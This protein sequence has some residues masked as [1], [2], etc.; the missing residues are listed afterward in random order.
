[1]IQIEMQ[2]L[3]DIADECV[4]MP[5]GMGHKEF[6][7][8][9]DIWTP[10]YRFLYEFAREYKP[11]LI[12]ECG[13][14]M[15]TASEHM[16]LAN[17]DGL[18]I[19]IDMGFHPASCNVV[20][21]RANVRYVHGN[22]LDVYEHVMMLSDDLPLELLFLDSEHDGI[23]A[24]REFEIYESLMGEQCLVACDDIHYNTE[25][26]VWWDSIRNPKMELNH[27]H[28]SLTAGYV[29]TGFGVFIVER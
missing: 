17:P 25:M 3:D 11:K 20:K 16:A 7:G 28:P 26:E 24:Q 14:Y 27:L 18:V 5:W 19:G 22:T 9:G 8:N 1:M 12:V 10:Y 23:T 2:R 6:E 4:N 13:V 21:R 29:D 15:G